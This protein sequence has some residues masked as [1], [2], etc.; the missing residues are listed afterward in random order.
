MKR[1]LFTLLVPLALP[2]E[3]LLSHGYDNNCSE[4]C[5]DYYCPSEHLREDKERVEKIIPSKK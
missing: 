1:L 2:L 5:N 4:E 3:P